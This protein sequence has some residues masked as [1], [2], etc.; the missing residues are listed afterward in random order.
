M[1]DLKALSEAVIEGEA[2]TVTGLV[3]TALAEGVPAAT[4]LSD[5]LTPG[6]LEVGELFQAE[7]IFLPE[8][9]RSAKAMISGID[10]LRPV[11]A[12]RD[13][14]ALATVVLG[15]VKGD[16]HD[17]GK[18]IVG[19]IMEGAGFRVI[20]LGTDVPSDRF[21]KAIVEHKAHVLGLSALLSTTMPEMRHVLSVLKEAGAR[22]G[23]K[24]IVGG[25]PVTQGFAEA[26]GADGYAADAPGAVKRA[27]A[28]LNL[29]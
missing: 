10:L 28:L 5:G 6:I 4:I 16:V 23:I 15:T 7:E 12:E 2:S 9:L 14:E 17:I 26:I 25:A 11:M 21:A 8:M 24:V 3:E 29:S 20:D 1:T 18:N 22:D 19:M 13:S 27:K